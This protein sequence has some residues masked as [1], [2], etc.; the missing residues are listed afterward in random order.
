MVYRRLRS[1]VGAHQGWQSHSHAE[2]VC[3][4]KKSIFGFPGK[5][6]RDPLAGNEKSCDNDKI[7]NQNAI[8]ICIFKT[9]SIDDVEKVMA[10]GK[11]NRIMLDNFTPEKIVEALQIEGI[12]QNQ[13]VRA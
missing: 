9:R 13:N 11:V 3:G 2:V 12:Q 6:N 1:K 7:G 8:D 10:V 5:P 4:V